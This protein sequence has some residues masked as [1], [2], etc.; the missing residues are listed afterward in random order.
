MSS[1]APGQSTI[2][3]VRV[4]SGFAAFLAL[5]DDPVDRDVAGARGEVVKAEHEADD[6]ESRGLGGPDLA[7]PCLGGGPVPMWYSPVRFAA[8]TILTS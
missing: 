4:H 3:R 2:G 1:S 6:A 5:D 8:L 7:D